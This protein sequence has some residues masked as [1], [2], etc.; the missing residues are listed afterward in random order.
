MLSYVDV[1]SCYVCRV[2]LRC[3]G[4]VVWCVVTVCVAVCCVVL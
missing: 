1:M 3:V 4:V 2:V